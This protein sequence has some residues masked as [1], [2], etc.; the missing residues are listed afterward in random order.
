M[1]RTRTCLFGRTTRTR[2]CLLGGTTR[3]RAW[4]LGSFAL[5]LTACGVVDDPAIGDGVGA[6]GATGASIPPFETGP[7]GGSAGSG[8]TPDPWAALPARYPPDQVL[9][10]ITP[11]VADELRAIA[12]AVPGRDAHVFMKAGASGTVS[13]NLLHC[14]AGL[15][16]AF[17]TVELGGETDLE[18]TID[19]FRAGDAAGTTPFDRPTLCAQVGKTAAWALGGSPSP[20]ESEIAAVDPRFAVVNYGTNDMQMGTTYRS[21]LFPFFANHSTLVDRL[22]AE[23]IVP[24]VS[25]LGPRGDSIA[26]ARWVPTYDAVTRAIAEARQVPYL[27]MFVAYADLPGL[28]LSGDG[29]HG[30]V[31]VDGGI[32]KPCVF[33]ALGLEHA[34]NTRNLY[35]LRA[36]DRM[37]RVVLDG[38]PA[39]DAPTPPVA[40]SGTAVDP[41]VVDRLPF[42]HTADTSTSTD[43]AIDAYPACDSGQDESGPERVYRFELEADTALRIVVLD[44]NGVDV[45]LHLLGD[46]P[47]PGSCLERRDRIIERALP[48]GVYHVVVDSFVA[49]GVAAAG[50]YTLVVLACEPGDPDC[51]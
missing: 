4:L 20:L 46:S 12:A 7:Q 6:G 17:Y 37:R 35:T 49:G 45:D 47:D 25:G 13:P 15:P 38:E 23:G 44:R 34:Y 9:S 5:G 18:A 1:T 26:A 11:V 24:L 8:G 51:A 36:F 27:D 41:F 16:G 14:F 22:L 30:N 21:A 19:H 3:T 10:P 42:T 40:G 48:A 29:L 50:P 28:G 31:Y 33:D 39:P 2:A 32:A 43:S